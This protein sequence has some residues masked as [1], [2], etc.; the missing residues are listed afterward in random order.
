MSISRHV[1]IHTESSPRIHPMELSDAFFRDPSLRDP[2]YSRELTPLREPAVFRDSAYR[3]P[4]AHFRDPFFRGELMP[5]NREPAMYAPSAL[6]ISRTF[7][8]PE[9]QLSTMDSEMARMAQEMRKMFADM[10]H[11]MPMDANPESWRMKENFLMD[12]PIHQSR[13]GDRMFRLQ[14][15]VRQFK[16]DEI[17]VKTIG[18]QLTVHAKH[19]EKGE[20]KSL[21]REYARQYILPKELNPENLMSKLNR[22]GVLTIEA[23]LPIKE[24]NHDRLIAIKHE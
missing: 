7:F 4:A 6:P 23:P 10:Q 8:N 9:R 19:E 24:G 21:N 22:D 1:P 20:G 16:P 11:L 2:F 13:S 12:N 18:N 5:Y 15:D 3:E 17:F 14:F